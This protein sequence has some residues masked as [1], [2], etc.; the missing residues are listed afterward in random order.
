MKYFVQSS[1]NVSNL[2]I[3][4]HFCFQLH[5]SSIYYLWAIYSKIIFIAFYADKIYITG[6]FNGQECMNTAEVYD[7]E[8]NQWTLLPNMRTRRSG[9]SCIS[10]HGQVTIF[11]TFWYGIHIEIWAIIQK[12]QNYEREYFQMLSQF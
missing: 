3:P 9:V 11:P 5:H 6:G 1:A 10:Y 2:L 8:T 12:L 4:R 7:P